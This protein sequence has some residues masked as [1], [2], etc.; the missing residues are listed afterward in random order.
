M[1]TN[2]VMLIMMTVL[3]CTFFISACS[4]KN[5]APDPSKSKGNVNENMNGNGTDRKAGIGKGGELY[6]TS[7]CGIEKIE[8]MSDGQ[9]YFTFFDDRTGT[10]LSKKYGDDKYKVAENVEKVYASYY[11][12]GGFQAFF[13]I[14]EDKTISGISGYI[15][16]S[17]KA[18]DG[19]FIDFTG[20]KNIV[21][22]ISINDD[23]TPAIYAVND[24][25]KSYMLDEY[26]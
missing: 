14:Y 20:L 25:G 7:L 3:L 21:D 9:L 17:K 5:S 24:Q 12:N 11:G 26:F 22:I 1:K 15:I 6:P 19:Y 23:G 10:E 2:K 8:L 13:W 4:D 18:I 16:Y